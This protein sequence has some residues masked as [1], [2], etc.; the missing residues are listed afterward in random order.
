[1][2]TSED[3]PDQVYATQMR[4]PMSVE[5]HD[6][7]LPEWAEGMLNSRGHVPLSCNH[8]IGLVAINGTFIECIIDTGGARTMLDK[9]TASAAGLSINLPGEGVEVGGC[10]GPS[11]GDIIY[12]HEVV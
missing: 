9:A 8:F 12:Y 6:T 7:S 11:R 4:M 5:E 3:E 1:M 2:P 10:Y